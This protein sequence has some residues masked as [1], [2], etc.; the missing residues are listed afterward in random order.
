MTIE[1]A[2]EE[3]PR[4]TIQNLTTFLNGSAIQEHLHWLEKVWI[5]QHLMDPKG[6]LHPLKVPL[7][8]WWIYGILHWEFLDDWNTLETL[9]WLVGQIEGLSLRQS[10]TSFGVSDTEKSELWGGISY[11]NPL[12]SQDWLFGETFQD[13][14]Q[15]EEPSNTSKDDTFLRIVIEELVLMRIKIVSSDQITLCLRK[16]CFMSFLKLIKHYVIQHDKLEA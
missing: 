5:L 15:I 14:N 4:R 7:N 6:E 8:V 11:L 12:Y 16:F 2:V 10:P 9:L 13:R 3:N 1:E